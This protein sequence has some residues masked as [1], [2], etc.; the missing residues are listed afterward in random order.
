MGPNKNAGRWLLDHQTVRDRLGACLDGA[1]GLRPR[2]QL[3]LH[4]A[5]CSSCRAFARTF[6]GTVALLHQ[7]PPARMADPARGRLRRLAVEGA[8]EFGAARTE[9]ARVL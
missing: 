4:L 6:G 9:V 3:K 1:L 2:R 5:G 8:R 7:V